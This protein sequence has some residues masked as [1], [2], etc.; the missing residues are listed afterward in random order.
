MGALAGAALGKAIGQSLNRADRLHLG[1]AAE[2]VQRAPLGKRIRWSNPSSG[3]YESIMPW[4]EGSHRQTGEQCRELHNQ[5]T[6][7]GQIL[8][9]TGVACQARDGNWTL[10]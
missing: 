1:L 2:T 8:E 3:N 9:Y 7:R 6:V 5:L 10:M 4:R